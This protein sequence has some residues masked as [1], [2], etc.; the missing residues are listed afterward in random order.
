MKM[1]YARKILLLVISVAMV[2]GGLTETPA[3]LTARA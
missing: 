3:G 1:G 2:V